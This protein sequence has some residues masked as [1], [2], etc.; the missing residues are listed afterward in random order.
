M[1]SEERIVELAFETKKE[2]GETL[3]KPYPQL[4]RDAY[5]EGVINVVETY[6]RENPSSYERY[7]AYWGHILEKLVGDD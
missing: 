2:T 4:V 5:K 7:K 3:L 1:I 6:K